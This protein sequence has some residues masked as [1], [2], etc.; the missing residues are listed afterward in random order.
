MITITPAPATGAA[1]AYYGSLNSDNYLVA[2]FD[3][4]TGCV[5]RINAG[6]ADVR[7]A[8][9]AAWVIQKGET[10]P[11]RIQETATF[12]DEMIFFAIPQAV[13]RRI[14]A[15][16]ELL[17]ASNFSDK[18]IVEHVFRAMPPRLPGQQSTA[19]ISVLVGDAGRVLKMKYGENLVDFDYDLTVV[20][21]G[22]PNGIYVSRDMVGQPLLKLS[23]V[24]YVDSIGD[25]VGFARDELQRWTEQKIA[26][27]R[28]LAAAARGAG[29]G[30]G[31]SP[32]VLNQSVQPAAG[33]A[34]SVLGK[35]GGVA[36]S[37]VGTGVVLIV[38]LVIARIK[39]RL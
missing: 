14:T 9:G 12:F 20:P 30:G 24:K 21:P 33:T 1:I 4:S 15:N 18:A 19:E 36:I 13:L 35:S 39:H 6:R 5:I 34:E 23:A 17:I 3:F 7:D 22:G 16:P 37:L 11:Q 28:P 8:E 26:A 32:T 25:P 29:P 10:I 38:L 27:S 31:E 2:A